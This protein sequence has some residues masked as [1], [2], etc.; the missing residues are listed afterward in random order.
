MN[1][2]GKHDRWVDLFLVTD[3]FVPALAPFDLDRG[4]QQIPAPVS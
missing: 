2:L 1:R 4:R 3:G